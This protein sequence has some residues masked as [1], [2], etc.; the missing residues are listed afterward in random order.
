MNMF[1]LPATTWIVILGVL[2]FWVVYTGVFYVIS[3]NWAVEDV[4]Y[5]KREDSQ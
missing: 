5:H 2:G 1:A 3:R 4:D